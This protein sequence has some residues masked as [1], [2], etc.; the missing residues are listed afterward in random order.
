[1]WQVLVNLL[2]SLMTGMLNRGDSK[3]SHIGA[4]VVCLLSI[5]NSGTEG[6]TVA[7]VESTVVSKEVSYV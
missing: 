6:R 4:K 1:M 3:R 2:L 7:V 5:Q